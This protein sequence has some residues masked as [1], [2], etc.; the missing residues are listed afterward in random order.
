MAIAG[1]G[2]SFCHAGAWDCGNGAPPRLPRRRQ[3][4][5]WGEVIRTGAVLFQGFWAGSW[6][7]FGVVWW[8]WWIFGEMLMDFDRFLEDFDGFFGKFDRFWWILSSIL[9]D[10]LIGGTGFVLIFFGGREL[11]T[12]GVFLKFSRSILVWELRPAPGMTGTIEGIIAMAIFPIPSIQM[13]HL[14]QVA[15]PPFEDPRLPI[16]GT[17]GSAWPRNPVWSVPSFSGCLISHGHGQGSDLS[18]V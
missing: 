12:S 17:D 6:W 15:L 1:P 9:I 3:W 14:C 18:T 11:N 8:V 13:L 2:D 7:D 10:W 5:G 16:G 4:A